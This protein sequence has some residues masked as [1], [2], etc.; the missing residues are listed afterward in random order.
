MKNYILDI[1]HMNNEYTGTGMYL[2]FFFL[3]LMAFAFTDREKKL[4]E[5]LILPELFLCAGVY[6]LLPFIHNFI[7]N[8]YDEEIR[9][10]LFWVL[11]VPAVA[12]AGISA[13]VRNI[14]DDRKKLMALLFFVPIIFFCGEFQLSDHMYQK[15]EN[16]YRLPDGAVRIAER[17]LSEKEEPKLIVPYTI[18]HPFRQISSDIRLLY[19][20]DAS[21]GRIFP[22]VDDNLYTVCDQM[23]RSYPDLKIVCGVARAYD[24]DYIVFD[25]TYH[26]LGG[27]EVNAKGYK[28]DDT[29]VGDRT[30]MLS[31][32]MNGIEI[33]PK[34][35]EDEPCWDLSG[36]G[37]SY[38]GTYG[39]YLLYRFE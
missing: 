29:Y 15:A 6:L 33:R 7:Y 20:E 14:K 32:S 3:T 37:L 11:M 28:A 19:G 34:G 10:R 31:V 1:I 8:F 23:E 39:Q 4:K 16:A 35:D 5:L 26:E 17:V 25:S 30:P 22:A 27:I 18:A 24:V 12:A 2:A 36:F 9:G 13:F 21:Y 38:D